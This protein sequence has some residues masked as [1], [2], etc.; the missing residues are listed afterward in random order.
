MDFLQTFLVLSYVCAHITSP[1]PSCSPTWMRTGAYG[2]SWSK[3]R[4][5]LL[6]GDI[7][8]LMLFFFSWM[9]EPF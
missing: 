6:F 9:N 5:L 7:V 2:G 8:Y 4:P 3:F 1:A